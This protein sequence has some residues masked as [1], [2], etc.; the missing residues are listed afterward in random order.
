MLPSS[1][2]THLIAGP[3]ILSYFY[4]LCGLNLWYVPDVI[5]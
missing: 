2:K 1:D 4:G 3:L 5:F